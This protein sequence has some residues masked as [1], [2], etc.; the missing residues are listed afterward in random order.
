[1]QLYLL[2]SLCVEEE[3]KGDIYLLYL[4]YV[5]FFVR[6]KIKV[7]NINYRSLLIFNKIYKWLSFLLYLLFQNNLSFILTLLF[8]L[9]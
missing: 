6:L 7:S 8:H 5:S 9:K 3:Q 4:R 2:F 1:M